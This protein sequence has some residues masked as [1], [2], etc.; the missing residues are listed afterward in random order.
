VEIA[1]EDNTQAAVTSGLEEGQ[2]VALQPAFA[3]QIALL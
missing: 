3:A 2:D 1:G